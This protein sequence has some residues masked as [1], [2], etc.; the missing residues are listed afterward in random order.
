M[1]SEKKYAAD[2][3]IVMSVSIFVCNRFAA[4]NAELSVAAYMVVGF[5]HDGRQEMRETLTFLRDI[6]ERGVNDLGSGYY[7]ALPGTELFRTLYEK[8]DIVIDREYFRHILNG[9]SIYPATSFS[10]EMGRA[11]LFYWKVRFVAAFYWSRMRVLGLKTVTSSI[12]ETLSGRTHH[13]K[14]Q[15]AVRVSIKNGYCSIKVLF[16]PR[17]I[18]MEQETALFAPWDRIYREITMSRRSA[19]IEETPVTDS[20]DLEDLNVINALRL[21]HDVARSLKLGNA[22]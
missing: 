4:A 9:L 12:Q 2:A 14:L 1:K 7:M 16:K 20:R 8:G 19:G 17:W 18:P 10:E 21:D 11:E 3:P 15:T 22:G 13:S 6:A 5:P